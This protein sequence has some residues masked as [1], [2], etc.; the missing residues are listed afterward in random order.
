MKHLSIFRLDS[1][2][3]HCW[4]LDPSWRNII[5]LRQLLISYITA[6]TAELYYGSYCSVIL[7]QLLLSYITAVID[8]DK[9]RKFSGKMLIGIYFW[10]V[11]IMFN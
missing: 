5:I 2:T 11:K 6:V 7:R 1:K 10:I 3:Q 9:Y 4:V 8:H